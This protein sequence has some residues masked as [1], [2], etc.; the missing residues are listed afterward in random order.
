MKRA[1]EEFG[2]IDFVVHSIAYAPL[3]DLKVNTIKCSREGFKQAMEISAYSLVAVAN[4][5]R[6]IMNDKGNIL[7][8]TYFG[9]ERAVPGYNVMG[10]C[11]AALD[12][13]VKY[14]AFDLGP[15]R[16]RVNAVS[17][18]PLRTL[19]GRGAGVD[20][21]LVLYEAMSPLG[22]NITHQEVGPHGGLPALAH[23]RGHHGRNPARRRRLQHYGLARPHA[24]KVSRYAE[25][26]LTHGVR[27][28]QRTASCCPQ[29]V[30][31]AIA[32][33]PVRTTWKER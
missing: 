9:G 32:H 4:A 21:M 18:G 19:A 20:D 12:S 22:R 25:N 27:G 10:V 2:K 7:T 14:L 24:G 26:K 16:I 28:K 33:M 11:K 5:A 30:A 1:G 29:K 23:G 15:R 31:T 17:A 6:D 8:M 3:E 13:I